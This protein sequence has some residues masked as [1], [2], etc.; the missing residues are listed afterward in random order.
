MED[1]IINECEFT[2]E[3][4]VKSSKK[5]ILRQTRSFSIIGA[6]LALLG[7]IFLLIK[8]IKKLE[9]TYLILILVLLLCGI[10]IMILP[11]IITLF[12]P[13]LLKKQNQSIYDGFNVR[14]LFSENEIDSTVIGKNAKSNNVFTYKHLYKVN[15]YGDVVFMYLN[16][17]VLYMFKLSGFKTEEEKDVVLKRIINKKI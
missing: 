15:I 14:I 17:N 3:E 7:F 12:M 13:S 5:A 8:L 16:S 11:Y 10:L 6:V 1:I 2:T 4:L 9:N